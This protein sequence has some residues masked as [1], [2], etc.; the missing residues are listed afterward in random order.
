M[1]DQ[2]A[3][4]FRTTHTVKTQQVVKSRGQHCGD[5][6]ILGYLVNSSG[7]VLLVLDLHL[8]HD[9]WVSSADPNLNDNLH[10]PNDKDRSLN[11][12]TDN[13]IRK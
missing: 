8:A 11:E 10:Y 7:P 9:R 12:T 5:I 1:V 13:K 3:D 4:L 6:E 2:I